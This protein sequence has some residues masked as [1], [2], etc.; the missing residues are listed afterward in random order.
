MAYALFYIFLFLEKEEQESE[1]ELFMLS[2][3]F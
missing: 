3:G 2:A 1:E